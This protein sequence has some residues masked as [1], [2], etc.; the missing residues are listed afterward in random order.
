MRSYLLR[1]LVRSISATTVDFSVVRSAPIILVPGF[2]LG[3][4]AWDEVAAHMRADG[5]DV[6]ALTLPG[7]ESVEVDRSAITLEDHVDAIRAA[8]VAAGDRVVLAVHSGAGAP[9]Y[10]VTDRVPELIAA[11]IYVDSAP[12]TGPVDPDMNDAELAMPDLEQLAAEENLEGLSDDQLATFLRRAVPEPGAALRESIP[13]HNDARLDV[14]STMICTGFGSE[15]IREAV[16]HGYAWLGGL[17]EL[18]D[19]T[20]VDLPTS[21]WPMWSRPR[22]LAAIISEVAQRYGTDD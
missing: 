11:M 2:W 17:A 10:A 16:S 8:V 14:P 4:W 15:Q 19:V 6:T 20:Y 22:D 3:A 1:C 21:H 13:L 12:A 9:G 5:H 7:L 18:H